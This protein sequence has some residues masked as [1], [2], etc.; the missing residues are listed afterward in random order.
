[1][2]FILSVF[3]CICTFTAHSQ[4]NQSPPLPLVSNHDS[5]PLGTALLSLIV[6]G[7]NFGDIEARIDTDNPYIMVSDLRQSLQ[8]DLKPEEMSRIF[9][10]ILSKLEWAGIADMK[11]AGILASWDSANLA[12]I[13]ST[14]SEFGSLK[15][16]D[17]YPPIRIGDKE[18]VKPSTIAGVL[19]V[20]VNGSFA[21]PLTLTSKTPLS[22]NGDT[23]L[24]LWDVAIESSGSIQFGLDDFT[25]SLGKFRSVYD[26]PSLKGRLL[27][28]KVNGEGISYQMLPEIYGISFKSLDIFE[29][30]DRINSP[31]VKFVL[32]EHS[33]VRLVTNGTVIRTMSLEKGIYRIFD[34]PFMYGLNDFE[35]QVSDDKGEAFQV[36]RPVTMLVSTESSLL[37]GGKLEYGISLGVG[38]SEPDQPFASGYLRYG[39][40][41]NLTTSA[42]LQA[43][44]RSALGGVTFVYTS[45]IGSFRGELGILGA[46][47]GRA[48]PLAFSTD[49]HYQFLRST[50]L[51]LPSF[52]LSFGWSSNGFT[53]PQPVEIIAA[54]DAAVRASAYIGGNI[55]RNIT[56]GLSG[57]WN[58]ILTASPIDSKSI[59]LNL[60]LTLSQETNFNASMGLTLVTDE[61]PDF[62]ATFTLSTV[63]QIRASSRVSLEQSI[64]GSNTINYS[65]SLPLGNGLGYSIEGRN[66]TGGNQGLSSVSMAA[67][68]SLD[69]ADI[70]MFGGIQYGGLLDTPPL[71]NVNMNI[72]SALAFAGGAFAFSRPISDSFVIF[73]PERQV[74]K[75]VNSISVDSGAAPIISHGA[76]VVLPLVSY[77]KTRGTVNFPEADADIG[78]SIPHSLL[79]PK[80]RSGILY[81]VSF[82]QQYSLHGTLK[83]ADGVPIALVA[84][85][86]FD[87]NGNYLDITFTFQDGTF[88]ITG[89]TPGV[90]TIRWAN[91]I[92]TNQL[93]LERSDESYLEL[94]SLVP[95]QKAE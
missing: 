63:N 48:N 95:Q 37:V 15:L 2:S 86:I 58:K 40:F 73:S 68:T 10:V 82:L 36:F 45:S 75:S 5:I 54:P 55:S 93:I 62:S 24:K 43:D 59:N 46:W 56:Y 25:A 8:T 50:K 89:L 87:S 72:A 52:G 9:D 26:I 83:D 21:F 22:V 17:F 51:T 57:F 34:L 42:F 28:G 41:Y 81:S 66:L 53:A 11:V 91:E 38:K 14:P 29:D 88:E 6:N 79:S 71:G 27:T 23:L 12:L 92:G 64:D 31:S 1:M 19:N 65:D 84:G 90:Y 33:I 67:R 39:L 80:Y 74:R 69:F 61:Q 32:E 16:I 47:D 49:I 35:L 4:N 13:I 44:M 78:P 94:G 30:F 77:R 3:L 20:T 76:P 60:G 85:E 70:S 7:N 18:W